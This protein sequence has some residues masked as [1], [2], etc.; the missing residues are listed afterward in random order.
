MG[1]IYLYN[2]CYSFVTKNIDTI[3]SVLGMIVTMTIAIIQGIL[4]NRDNKKSNAT[5]HNND[6]N[7]TLIKL[8]ETFTITFDTDS[9]QTITSFICKC[10]GLYTILYSHNLD[11]ILEKL[12]QE[13]AHQL[14]NLIRDDKLSSNRQALIGFADSLYE[15]VAGYKKLPTHIEHYFGDACNHRYPPRKEIVRDGHQA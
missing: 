11:P 12:L 1:L 14:S 10:R 8:A 3:F 4:R 6:I 7:M 2:V 13:I 9:Q 15:Y 5:R